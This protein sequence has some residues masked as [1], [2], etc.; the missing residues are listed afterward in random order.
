MA[1]NAFT[2]VFAHT[3][4]H[5]CETDSHALQLKAVWRPMI[6]SL[7]SS[8]FFVRLLFLKQKRSARHAKCWRNGINVFFSHLFIFVP[9]TQ[10]ILISRAVILRLS[11]I[12]QHFYDL[13]C[14]VLK[15]HP[16]NYCFSKRRWLDVYFVFIF[17]IQFVNRLLIF[18]DR[19]WSTECDVVMCMCMSNR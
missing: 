9:L 11:S 5:A 13:F 1:E 3:H 4:T 18:L 12:K 10:S 19:L 14:L 16:T 8:T 7:F 6:Y 15:Y 17:K 2:A